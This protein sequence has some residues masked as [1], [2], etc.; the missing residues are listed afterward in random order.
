MTKRKE[1][2]GWFEDQKFG[3]AIQCYTEAMQLN[4]EDVTNVSNRSNAFY[5][6]RFYEESARDARK[7]IDMDP[8]FAKASSISPMSFKAYASL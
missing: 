5:A 2:N 8:T 6:G 4:P 1:G 3:M 7:C